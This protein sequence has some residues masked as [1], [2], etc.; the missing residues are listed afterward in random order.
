VLELQRQL[1]ALYVDPESHSVT[2][3]WGQTDDMMMPIV[4]HAV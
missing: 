2:D 4:D 3:R 1:L